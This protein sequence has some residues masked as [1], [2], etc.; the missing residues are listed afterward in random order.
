MKSKT[1]IDKQL[2]RKTSDSVRETIIL[3]KKK[4]AWVS[5]AERLSAPRRR[6]PQVNLDRVAEAAQEGKT[7]VVPGK[8]LSQGFLD[9]KV[10]IVALAFSDAAKQKILAAQGSVHTLKEEILANPTAKEVLILS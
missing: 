6:R 4:D 7:I 1:T 8:V 5:I 10:K 2:R 3:A 9:K